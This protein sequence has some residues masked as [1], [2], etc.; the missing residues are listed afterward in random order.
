MTFGDLRVAVVIPA[1]D[2]EALI[3]TAIRSVPEWVD[4][5]IVVDDG[6]TD[7]TFARA[8]EASTNRV[9]IVRHEVNLGVGA[10]IG[11]GYRL[12]F[13]RGADV[14]AVMAGDAQMDPADLGRLVEP[15]ARDAA[16]YVKGDRLGHPSVRSEMPFARLLG[17]H[18]LSWLTRLAVGLPSVSDSQ[19]GY[20][21]L[22]R[23]ACRFLDLDVIYPR[24]GYPNDVFARLHSAGVRIASIVVRPVYGAEKSGI[25]LWTA[26][27]RI[28]L[29]LARIFGRRVARSWAR[30]STARVS[31][32]KCA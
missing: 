18:V 27:F 24:Y 17:N 12:A 14:A 7:A 22:S 23:A 29:L 15:I 10:A 21:V 13:D 28:P 19:C 20:T 31:P 30:R 3:S 11:T 6:S 26:L 8:R 2:E 16:D 32:Q 5:V 1:F 25:T 9:S 4:D